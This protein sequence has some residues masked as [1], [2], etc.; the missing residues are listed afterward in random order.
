MRW[1]KTRLR[2]R[3]D[4]AL[5]WGALLGGVNWL[6]HALF[7]NWAG[8]GELVSRLAFYL[9]FSVLGFWAAVWPAIEW[10]YARSS[11]RF[12]FSSFDPS[13]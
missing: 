6:A 10:D 5:R 11:K 9:A 12:E 4:F 1:R 3:S 7:G 2:G 8:T 13:I